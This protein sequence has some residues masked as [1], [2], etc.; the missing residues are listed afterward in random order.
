MLTSLG[1][2]K[3]VFAKIRHLRNDFGR[4]VSKIKYVKIMR[5]LGE[6]RKRP[7]RAEKRREQRQNPYQQKKAGAR[8]R[9][10]KERMLRAI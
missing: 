7:H 3:N 1:I 6:M 9:F 5:F 4:I 2:V 10:F 8:K